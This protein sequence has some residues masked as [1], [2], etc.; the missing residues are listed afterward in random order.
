[1]PSLAERLLEGERA[2]VAD[3]LNCIDDQRPEAREQA[4]ALL[5][6]LES[7]RG[8]SGALRVGITGAPGAGKSTLLDACVRSLR[9]EHTTVGV[10]AVDP[11]SP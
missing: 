4:V 2:A 3:A 1:M 5:A 6:A 10:I 11:S 8:A 7:H 9:Q